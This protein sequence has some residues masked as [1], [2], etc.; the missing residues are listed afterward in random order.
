LELGDLVVD[1]ALP[2][3]GHPGPLRGVGRAVGGEFGQRRTG[4]LQRQADPLGGPDERDP[5]Q[6]R[7][8]I[9]TLAARRAFGPD[10]AD[11]FVIA[12]RRRGQATAG[13]ELSDGQAGGRRH[14]AQHTA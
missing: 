12:Q 10:E 11:L 7:T 3:P 13:G 2:G 8:V 4:L 6:H 5:A 14:A 9:S 1:A